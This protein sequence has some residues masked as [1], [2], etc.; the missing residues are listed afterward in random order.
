[1]LNDKY[2]SFVQIKA[3]STL[4]QHLDN[5]STIISCHFLKIFFLDAIASLEFEYE[6]KSS[7]HLAIVPYV[8]SVTIF[9]CYRIY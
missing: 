8:P 4:G 9:M 1:M 2:F 5:G 3:F 6:K 7:D